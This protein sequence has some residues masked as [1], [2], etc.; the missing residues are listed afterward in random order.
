MS[1]LVFDIGMHNGDDTCYYLAS[2]YRVVAV[3]ADPRMCEA[4]RKRFAK[5]ISTGQL[6]I[7]N[8]GIAETE[9]EMD[10]W[11]SSTTEW[12]SFDRTVATRGGKQANS[13]KV[14]TIPFRSLL[15]EEGT[16]YFVKIDIEGSDS[17]CINDLASTESH[18][19]YVSFEC[20]HQDASDIT[21]L[22]SLGYSSF[23]CVRQND[24]RQITP[25]NLEFQQLLRRPI[26]M[27]LDRIP[28]GTGIS[29]LLRSALYRGHYRL[30]SSNGRKPKRW[31]SGP[32]SFELPGRWLTTD[33]ILSVWHFLA[34]YD[35]FL[36]ADSTGEW[37][38][39]H[40][41]Y[42]TDGRR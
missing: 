38:D 2:G 19:S 25:K 3:D 4:G 5:E 22:A 26:T 27:S 7:R 21:I 18:P 32:P 20:N 31:S 35:L 23:K 34:A 8:V 10:F 42:G 16:P 17:L 30:Q 29:R 6:S 40:A 14:Q 15:E 39:I 36:H 28:K 12:S 11:V 13:I 33:E 41:A 1:D 24:F 37:F 9:G